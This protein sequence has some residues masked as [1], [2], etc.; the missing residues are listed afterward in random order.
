M[1]RTEM[2]KQHREKWKGCEACTLCEHRKKVVLYRGK[3]PCDVLF[4]GEG[5]GASEDVFGEPFVGPAGI[6]LDKMI[7]TASLTD[8]RLGFTNLVGCL[9][10]YDGV[11]KDPEQKEIKACSPRLVEMVKLA[12]PK[13]I[14]FVGNLAKKFLPKSYPSFDYEHNSITIIHP[15]AVLRMDPSQKPLATQNNVVSLGSLADKVAVAVTP[16]KY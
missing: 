6:L 10:K 8:F 5:P 4:V 3:I 7:E 14:V 11:I 13:F 12:S 15:G 2:W 1:T 9:P 16:P